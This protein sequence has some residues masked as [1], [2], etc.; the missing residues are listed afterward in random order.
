MAAAVDFRLDAERP[1]VAFNAAYMRGVRDSG[2]GQWIGLD[3]TVADRPTL[4][5]TS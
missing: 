1:S 4:Q 2:V 3:F 5:R